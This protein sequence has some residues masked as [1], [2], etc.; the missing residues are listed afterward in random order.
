[1]FR[2]RRFRVLVSL[3]CFLIL[4]IYYLF[5]TGR[6]GGQSAVTF[7]TSKTTSSSADTGRDAPG[8]KTSKSWLFKNSRSG[9]QYTL[10]GDDNKALD[11]EDSLEFPHRK[12]FDG[13]AIDERL[14][15]GKHDPSPTTT[16][17]TET[18]PPPRFTVLPENFPVPEDEVIRLPDGKPKAIP[19][20]QHNF[21]RETTPER[22]ERLKKLKR[23]KKTFLKHWA[24]YKEFAWDHDEL[25]PVSGGFQDPFAGWRATLVDTLDVL[26]IMGLKDEFEEAVEE[27]AHIDFKTTK[28]QVLPLF[29]VAI[30][31]MGGLIA[32]YDISEAKYPTLLHKAEELA[33]VLMGAFD[34]PNRMPKTFYHWRTDE[35]KML[36]V[37]SGSTVLAE[38]GSLTMEF[39]RMAQITRNDR[40]YDAV[41]RIMDEFEALQNNTKLPGLWPL[42]IDASGGCLP[43]DIIK[44]RLEAES[45][46]TISNKG[47]FSDTDMAKSSAHKTDDVFKDDSSRTAASEDS[48]ELGRHNN[49]SSRQGTIDTKIGRPL[50]S[51]DDEMTPS[52]KSHGSISEPSESRVIDGQNTKHATDEVLKKR[53]PPKYDEGDDTD[54]AKVAET[55]G[56]KFIPE[57]DTSTIDSASRKDRN[58][59][60]D[61]DGGAS[62]QKHETLKEKTSK[63]I[64]QEDKIGFTDDDAKEPK[65]PSSNDKLFKGTVDVKDESRASSFDSNREF[66]PTLGSQRKI[67][68]ESGYHDKTKEKDKSSFGDDSETQPKKSLSKDKSS[69]KKHKDS[70]SFGEDSA[71][72]AATTQSN[73]RRN[74]PMHKCVQRG[75]RSASGGR[76]H[77]RFTLGGMADSVYEYLPKT[78]L[79]LGG[80]E[81]QYRRM[82]EHAMSAMKKYLLFRTMTETPKRPVFF[83]GDFQT[84]GI[85][86]NETKRI[87]GNLVP[88]TGHLTCFQGAFIGLAAR[89]FRNEKDLDLARKL[90]D[91]CIWAYEQTATGIMPE[92]LD[93]VPCVNLTG[94]CKWNE[95]RWW[96]HIDPWAKEKVAVYQEMAADAERGVDRDTITAAK[97]SKGRGSSDDQT[98]KHEQKSADN[99]K[100]KE[101]RDVSEKPTQ[102]R[103]HRMWDYL[104]SK[105]DNSQAPSELDHLADKRRTPSDKRPGTA[106][107]AKAAVEAQP[108]SVA[109]Y[110]EQSIK[111]QRLKPGITKMGAREY[112]LRPEAIESVFYMYRITGDPYFREK[113]WKMFE[114][115]DNATSTVHGN[116]AID[117]V[118]VDPKVVHLRDKAESFWTAETL[119]YFWLLFSEPDVVSLDDWVFNTEAHPFRRP[120]L[121]VKRERQA[122]QTRRRKGAGGGMVWDLD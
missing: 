6:W 96:E 121:D 43:G 2:V 47:T 9:S 42:S 65:R 92:L 81:M 80:Q 60:A 116:S 83:T 14:P 71:I 68:E 105:K 25:R 78:F 28:K 54:D 18:A 33:E 73:V 40:Y 34:T 26:W 5:D 55:K 38:I 109:E 108:T 112:I 44:E 32:A 30:R 107:E 118:S 50:A 19:K 100:G 51:D 39:T 13:P 86:N 52:D 56:S 70:S 101:T 84:S 29:E 117:D 8:K 37:G 94:P 36:T 45:G 95:T 114:A 90:T 53:A 24:G 91:G 113:G 61:D 104:F 49:P 62:G 3:T 98:S 74:K 7:K 11:T 119:K 69:P 59:F 72:D 12:G 106:A 63:V 48:D 87:E 120:D 67:S 103:A 76:G 111:N 85:Y 27:V 22:R 31:Y 10:S 122:E 64:S 57:H 89:A 58:N 102:V 23:L 15:K 93:M 46:S 88:H 82:H 110:M 20:I 97:E 17:T 1:M 41:A 77:D 4:G 115:I 66:H 99:K 21:A 35:R 79:L 75:L 16:T